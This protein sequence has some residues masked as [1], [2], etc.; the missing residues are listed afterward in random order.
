MSG[1]LARARWG[2]LAL[3]LAGC[4]H[5]GALPAAPDACTGPGA[6]TAGWTAVDAGPFRVA[7]PPGY[8][9][10]E[11]RGIDSYVGHWDGPGGSSLH[12]DYGAYSSSL[13]ELAAGLRDY[14]ECATDIGGH[15][16]RVVAGYDADGNFGE[17]GRKYMV[18][19]AWR[20]VPP[21]AHLTL[22]ASSPRGADLPALLSIVRS[23]RFRTP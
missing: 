6:A 8:Q 9:R 14:R 17:G 1:T 18:A 21:G 2:V 15:P 11:V 10:R 5:A 7:V 3:A 20:S 23:V 4:A 16:A 22:V 13:N 12:F 19:A